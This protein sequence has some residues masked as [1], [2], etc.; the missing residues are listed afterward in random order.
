MKLVNI[1]KTYINK[2]N[3]MEA[4]KNINL[5]FNTTGLITILGPSG[6]G[7]T[8]LLNIMSGEDKD[9]EGELLDVPNMYYLTQDF[10]LFES[11][12]V[13]DNLKIASNDIETITN[14]LKKFGLWNY[15]HKKIKKCSNGQKK[16]TQFIRALLHSPELLLCD[17]PTAALDHENAKMLMEALKDVSKNMLVIVVTHDIALAEKYS[18][19][20]IRMGKGIIESD[21]QISELSSYKS[22][23]KTNKKTVL[24]TFQLVLCEFKSRIFEHILLIS[25]FFLSSVLLFTTINLYEN[26]QEQSSFFGKFKRGSNIVESVPKD[27]TIKIDDTEIE[28]RSFDTIFY[29]DIMNTVQSSSDI[30]GVEVFYNNDIY[31]RD[32]DTIIDLAE[33]TKQVFKTTDF[34]LLLFDSDEQYYSYDKPLNS[35][36]ILGIEAINAIEDY[37]EN[38]KI[39]YTPQG[40]FPS[41]VDAEPYEIYRKD[42]GISIID[43]ID[44]NSIPL[45]YGT[46]PINENEVILAKDTAEILMNQDGYNSLEE[47]IG[48]SFYIGVE[49]QQNYDV[50][51]YYYNPCNLDENLNVCSYYLLDSQRYIDRFEMKIAGISNIE[52]DNLNLVFF[53]NDVAQNPILKYYVRDYDQLYFDYVRFILKT[54]VDTTEFIEL[55]MS[56]IPTVESQFKV[57]DNLSNMEDVPLYKQPS[58]FLLFCILIF[59]LF[60]SLIIMTYFFIR[61]RFKKEHRIMTMIGYSSKLEKLF[62]VSLISIISFSLFM[63]IQE[64][65]FKFVNE[66]VK[67]VDFN[68]LLSFDIYLTLLSFLLVF[69][70]GLF[71]ELLLDWRWSHD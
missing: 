55:T 24:E 40:E 30:I 70:I 16:R 23:P 63:V 11:M 6:C 17:E 19:R 53:N 36:F 14:H 2:N 33:I 39:Y 3:T 60:I 66:I 44:E 61:K 21:I 29:K 67:W 42:Y 31:R 26:I 10:L 27:M 25:L 58:Y 34:P 32:T 8:T 7:K 54:D 4:L 57:F 56:N 64:S 15:R 46:Y 69:V 35:A 68:Y 51:D 18:D 12:S 43:L 1:R 47:M 38:F 37:E 13:L 71:I 20:I 65:L 5:E 49:S 41:L 9:F 45:S 48:Q 22:N 62:H 28:Y 52:T 50:Y 59:S